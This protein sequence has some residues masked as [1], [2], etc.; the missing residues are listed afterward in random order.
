MP[1]CASVIAL[2]MPC[3][4]SVRLPPSSVNPVSPARFR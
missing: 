4:T 2:N 3:A 1:V